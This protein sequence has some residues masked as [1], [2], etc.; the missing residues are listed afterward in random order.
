MTAGT[1]LFILIVC[2]EGNIEFFSAWISVN[3]G[4]IVVSEFNIY[5]GHLESKERFAIQRY[6]LI[7]GKKKNMKVLWHTFTYFST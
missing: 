4:R 1:E 6:L 7:I 2:S 5:E 3:L